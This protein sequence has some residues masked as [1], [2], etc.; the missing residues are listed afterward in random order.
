[1]NDPK[2]FQ[3]KLSELLRANK[4]AIV[5]E[6]AVVFVPLYVLLIT[7]VRLGGDDFT[8]LGGELYLLG[9]PLSIWAWSSR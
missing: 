4:L 9:G 3:E 5:L 2:P 8:P 1:M 6:I 7:S